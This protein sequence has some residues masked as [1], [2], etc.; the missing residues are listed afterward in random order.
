MFPP[1]IKFLT[2]LHG[3][4]ADLCFIRDYFITTYENAHFSEYEY[5]VFPVDKL[6]DYVVDLY[7]LPPMLPVDA[8]SG[9]HHASVPSGDL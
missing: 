4:F 5:N 7:S 3:G 2:H 6:I 8:N 1:Q 9:G